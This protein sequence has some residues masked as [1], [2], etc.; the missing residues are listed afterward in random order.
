[1]ICEFKINDRL[2]PAMKQPARYFT[3]DMMPQ[4]AYPKGF[5]DIYKPVNGDAVSW[6][7]EDHIERRST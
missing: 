3:Q 2:I 1:M 7:I 4:V 6:I 5:Q